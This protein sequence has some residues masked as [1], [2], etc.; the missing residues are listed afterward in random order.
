MTERINS[1]ED[2]QP[3]TKTLK[4]LIN[5]PF[6]KAMFVVQLISYVLI[7]GSPAIGALIGNQFDLDTVKTGA[8]IFGVF[9]SGEVLFYG[10]LFFLG[11][12]LLLLMKSKVKK[13]FIKKDTEQ[14]V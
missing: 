7:M 1:Q 10:S 3:K 5:T 9:I 4:D 13:W 6:K 11:K 12:E 8:V 2:P 14:N